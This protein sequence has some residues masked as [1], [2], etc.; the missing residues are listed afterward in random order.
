MIWASKNVAYWVS[1]S[2]DNGCLFIVEANNLSCRWAASI[3]CMSVKD[4]IA[5][6]LY[7]EEPQAILIVPQLKD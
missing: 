7:P 5:Y 4:A 6:T 1:A 2:K 3:Q